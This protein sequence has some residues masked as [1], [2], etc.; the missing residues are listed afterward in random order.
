MES[1]M[2]ISAANMFEDNEGAIKLALKAMLTVG[3]RTLM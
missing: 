3:S 2:R 1:V